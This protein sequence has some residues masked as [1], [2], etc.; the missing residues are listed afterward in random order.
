MIRPANQKQFQLLSVCSVPDAVLAG[1]VRGLRKT[2]LSPIHL[3]ATS[4]RRCEILS[5]TVGK[6][7]VPFFGGG[8][9]DR[10]HH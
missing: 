9:R 3:P 8:A 4:V 10:A 7:D 5:R 6:A 2:V 1:T